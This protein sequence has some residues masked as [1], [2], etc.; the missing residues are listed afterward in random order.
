MSRETAEMQKARA[1][2]DILDEVGYY[3]DGL[4]IN[5]LMGMFF[6]EPAYSKDVFAW[7]LTE[8][9]GNGEIEFNGTHLTLG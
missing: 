7:A 9:I 4:T 5:E 1:R 3:G 8:M 2:V 6:P